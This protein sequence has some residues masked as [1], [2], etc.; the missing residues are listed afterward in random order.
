MSCARLFWLMNVTR[1]PARIVTSGGSNL[2]AEVIT[3]VAESVGAGGTGAVGAEGGV[4]LVGVVGPVGVA[5]ADDPLQ[6]TSAISAITVHTT[7]AFI[8]PCLRFPSLPASTPPLLRR[9]RHCYRKNLREMLKPRYQSSLFCPPRAMSAS[10]VPKPF[11]KFNWK[12]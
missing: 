5:G 9:L 8:V 12:L 7:F 3:M 2:F 10:V 11:E 1:P 6:P 4:E